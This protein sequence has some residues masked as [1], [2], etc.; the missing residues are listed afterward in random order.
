VSILRDVQRL[1]DLAEGNHPRLEKW[2]LWNVAKQ[3]ALRAAV[4]LETD[5]RNGEDTGAREGSLGE[6][7]CQDP[8]NRVS[9]PDLSAM[10]EEHLRRPLRGISRSS[11]ARTNVVPLSPSK[12]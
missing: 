12:R 9:T 4:V 2:A 11:K 5:W 10:L 6:N 1:I 7:E 8:E 3:R